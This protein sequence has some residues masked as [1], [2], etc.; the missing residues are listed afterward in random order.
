VISIIIPAHNEEA[1]IEHSLATLTRGAAPGELEVIVVCNGC[2]D[3]TAARARA[4]GPPV[5][6]IET[7]VPSKA[8]ALNLGDASATGFPR[9]YSDADVILTL[10]SIRELACALEKDGILA[11]APVAKN[12]FPPKTSWPVRAYY[13]FWMALPYVQEGMMAAG[14]YAVNRE[15][16]A[17]FGDFPNVIADD[18]YFRLQYTGEERIEVPTAV[19]VVSAPAK[20]WDLILIK[21]RSRLGFYQLRDRFPQLFT[22]EAKSKNYGGAFVAILKKPRLWPC[23]VPY[24]WVNVVSRHRAKKQ[25]R[26]LAK[27]YVWE[28]DNSSRVFVAAGGSVEHAGA[29]AGPTSG[30]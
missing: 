30:Q 16:R 10:E 21:S 15:G 6:V 26:K 20:F 8:N 7:D 14:V 17:R 5:R 3:A 9:I 22:R 27:E 4:F 18:G 24:I 1:V 2:K 13:D 28:R 11:V 12:V 19:S 29:A 25:F 23:A